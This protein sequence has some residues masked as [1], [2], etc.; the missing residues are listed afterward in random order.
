MVIAHRVFLLKEAYGDLLF[1]CICL[2]FAWRDLV[3]WFLMNLETISGCLCICQAMVWWSRV[4]FFA[5]DVLLFVKAKV[6]QAKVIKQVLDTFTLISGLKVNLA[7]SVIL[8]SKCV[9]ATKKE[10]INSTQ[11][12]RFTPRIDRYLGFKVFNGRVEKGGSHDILDRINKKLS[13]W[14]GKLLNKPGRLTPWL[15]G[16]SFNSSLWNAVA[17]VSPTCL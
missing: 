9:P 15:F 13:L 10:K 12:I 2:S 7:K 5:D 4:Y 8:A 11:N 14:K 6:S 3:K 17:M 1:L 16:F